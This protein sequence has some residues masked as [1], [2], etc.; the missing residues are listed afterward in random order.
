MDMNK[1]KALGIG[2]AIVYAVYKYGKGDAVKAA[3]LGVGGVM[4]AK[5]VPFVRDALA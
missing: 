1:I 3:A 2:L 4:V 5:N